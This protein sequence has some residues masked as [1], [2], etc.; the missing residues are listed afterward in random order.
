MVILLNN[1]SSFNEIITASGNNCTI[2]KQNEDV[3]SGW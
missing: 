2:E 1:R 3:D